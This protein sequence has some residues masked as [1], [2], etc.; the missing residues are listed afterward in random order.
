MMDFVY[1]SYKSHH[2]GCVADDRWTRHPYLARKLFDNLGT[3]DK[4]GINIIV[5]GSKGKGTISRL[6][7]RIFRAHGLKTGLFTS[8]H[9]QTY[10]E[11]ISLNGKFISNS[12]LG[13]YANEVALACEPI[14]KDLKPSQYIGPM[15]IGAAM[16]LLY[17]KDERTQI[18]IFECGRG[19]RFDDVAQI[20]SD[21]SV[22]N[23][24]FEEHIP[25][26]GSDLT[27]VA[28]HKAGAILKSQKKVFSVEQDPKVKTVFQIEAQKQNVDL[29]FLVCDFEQLKLCI[30][31]PRYNLNN[32]HLAFGVAK[33]I[34]GRNFNKDIS[35]ATIESYP[36][37][38]CLEKICDEPPIFVDGCIH[39]TCAE[40][41][42]KSMKERDKTGVFL[43]AVPDNKDYKGVAHGLMSVSNCMILTGIDGT[44]LPFSGI[45][46]DFV[47]A[48]DAENETVFYEGNLEKAVSF[49]LEKEK[50]LKICPIYIVG[51]QI[52]LGRTKEILKNMGLI[53]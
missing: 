12:Q 13:R 9:Q 23:R 1:R 14:E 28:W 26:L 32:G 47:N 46:K 6:L 10:N 39:K 29:N 36:F 11:R 42:A 31:G 24:V 41:I 35:K 17:F 40:D 34:L 22:I 37:G 5:T 30:V 33:N 8:P 20:R 43:V 19:A 27:Q 44:H 49:A 18:N 21:Y 7:E 45:Q 52:F 53:K 3:P 50:N 2:S 51:T 4:D 16:A 15:A 48:L 25:L 38:G